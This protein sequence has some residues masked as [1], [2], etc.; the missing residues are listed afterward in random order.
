MTAQYYIDWE[1]S[2]FPRVRNIESADGCEIPMTFSEAKAEII[3]H[4]QN[5]IAHA[6]E[7]VRMTRA[8]RAKDITED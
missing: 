1:D 6:R 5:D 7:Q 8:L 3:W 2:A 4:F